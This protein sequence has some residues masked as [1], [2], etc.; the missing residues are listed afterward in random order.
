MKHRLTFELGPKGDVLE[1][2]GDVAGLE[3]LK[4]S[5]DKLVTSKSATG[6]DHLMAEAWSGHELSA[7]KAGADNTL[8]NQ[9]NVYRW[10]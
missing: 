8:I 1:I 5:L 6:H 3:M 2:H 9:V 4:R 10:K 7:D